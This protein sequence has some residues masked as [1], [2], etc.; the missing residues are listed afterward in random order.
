MT[1]LVVQCIVPRTSPFH[2][3][4]V[5]LFDDLRICIYVYYISYLHSMDTFRL[6][7]STVAVKQIS[8]S[9][10]GEVT[11]SVPRIL[12]VTLL[13]ITVLL[14]LGLLLRPFLP[15]LTFLR[16]SVSDSSCDD[17]SVPDL[18]NKYINFTICVTQSTLFKQH[19]DQIQ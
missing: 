3:D 7:L 11:H 12:A 15:H 2:S 16:A 4:S 6:R 1:M 10:L 13:T 18:Q 9:C 17:S 8:G 5:F 14:L 19:V